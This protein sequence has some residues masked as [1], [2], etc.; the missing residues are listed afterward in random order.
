M[1]RRGITI[2]REVLAKASQVAGKVT[3]HPHVQRAKE[4][5][6]KAARGVQELLKP[7][8]P[9]VYSRRQSLEHQGVTPEEAA[10]AAASRTSTGTALM[11][12]AHPESSWKHW[13]QKFEKSTIYSHVKLAHSKLEKTKLYQ[14]SMKAKEK[15]HDKVEEL[16]DT[17]ET[18]QNPL[19][20]RV[21]EVG[22]SI[23]AES[24]TSL[25]MGELKRMDPKF[26]VP[27]LMDELENY[28]IP[29][30]VTAWLQGDLDILN[31]VCEDNAKKAVLGE[32]NRRMTLGW[33]LDDRIL[34]VSHIDVRCLLERMSSLSVVP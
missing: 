15:V 22:D 25:A 17:Y 4:A 3:S 27:E 13:S 2:V 12:V 31:K 28:M 8:E 6:V 9:K 20:W 21:R 23:M 26:S 34:D 1:T 19:V 10:A 24:D 14:S 30:V 5:T 33:K 16:R 32:I 18:S 11:E 7:E 29:K